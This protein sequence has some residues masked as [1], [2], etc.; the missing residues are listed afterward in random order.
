[1][2]KKLD[3][4]LSSLNATDKNIII[5]GDLN[6]KCIKYGGNQYSSHQLILEVL[7]KQLQCD[8]NAL[9]LLIKSGNYLD[10][11]KFDKS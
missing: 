3:T 1:M 2:V 7:P 10:K 9:L 6:F 8:H 5:V 11:V 4:A